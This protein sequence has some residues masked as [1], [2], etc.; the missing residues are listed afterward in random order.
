MDTAIRR[1]PDSAPA[2]DDGRGARPGA[3]LAE[4]TVGDGSALWELAKAT[5]LDENSP[6]A[7]LMVCRDFART[8]VAARADDGMLV[9]F[10]TGYR[11]PDVADTLFVWQVGV[12]GRARRSG[13]A[14]AMLA[15]LRDRLVP[16]GV[17]YV[18]AT[19][20]P[21]N[22]AS[23]RLFRRFAADAGAE[24]RRTP[25]FAASA[26]PAVDP[27]HDA[28]ALYRIGPLPAGPIPEVEPRGGATRD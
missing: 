10:V 20:T 6:Y 1:L 9:G 25:L 18:E 24:V 14:S 4:P 11:R 26:F 27:P 5:G 17:R 7:Y 19:V 12:A 13:L 28:E 8:S 21:G 2:T 3:V 15:H 23:D 22:V 16:E